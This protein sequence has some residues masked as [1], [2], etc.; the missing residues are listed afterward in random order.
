MEGKNLCPHRKY[1]LQIC[2]QERSLC[3]GKASSE[4]HRNFSVSVCLTPVCPTSP[5]LCA[6][7]MCVS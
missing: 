3:F 7:T 6:E 5:S 1:S 2:Q 4:G